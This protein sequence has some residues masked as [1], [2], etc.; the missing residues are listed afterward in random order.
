MK[1][2]VAK[3]FHLLDYTKKKGEDWVVIEP[4]D[5][6]VKEIPNPKGGDRPWLVLKGTTVG[7]TK[8][9]ILIPEQAWIID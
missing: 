9:S 1:I 6:E 8:S 5:Y 7:A 2:R 4:G 3:R